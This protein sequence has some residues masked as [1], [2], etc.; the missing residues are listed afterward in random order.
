MGNVQGG[1]DDEDAQRNERSM[2]IQPLKRNK[3]VV[4]ADWEHRSCTTICHIPQEC[5]D[6]RVHG[7]RIADARR[8]CVACSTLTR[9][10]C[11][12]CNIF[13]CISGENEENCFW[14]VHNLQDFR[15]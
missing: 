15:K 6:E 7:E 4:L 9:I 10:K 5:K 11:T 3:S 1:D 12:N 8:H 14:R 2:F 13:C